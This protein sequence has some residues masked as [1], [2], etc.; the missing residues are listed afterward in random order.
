MAGWVTRPTEVEGSQNQGVKLKELCMRNAIGDATGQSWETFLSR[1]NATS[2]SSSSC[3]LAFPP[4][5]IYCPPPLSTS[6]QSATLLSRNVL[7]NVAQ[8]DAPCSGDLMQ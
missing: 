6:H 2:S 5:H 4:C 3:T 7:T 8:T 1:S